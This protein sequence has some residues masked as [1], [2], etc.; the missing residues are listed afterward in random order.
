L[1]DGE[2]VI[3]GV[4]LAP[5]TCTRAVVT[6]AQISATAVLVTAVPAIEAGRA[7]A[8][9]SSYSD[10]LRVF[11]VDPG[12]LI[13]GPEGQE[14]PPSGGQ[15]DFLER[16]DATAS[17][18]LYDVGGQ[19]V[20]GAYAP[21]KYGWGVLVEEDG[22]LFDVEVPNAAAPTAAVLTGVFGAVFALVTWFDVRR[23]RAARRAEEDR[24][25]FLSIVGHE[26]RTPLTVI[27][28]YT[29]TLAARWD[30]LDESSRRM[31][32]E[33]MAP[34]A[35]RQARVIEH[36]LTAAALQAGT[37][38]RPAV[39]PMALP[40]VLE[41]VAAEY[42]IVAPL[43]DIRV[44]ASDVPPVLASDQSLGQI[45]SELLDNAVRFSPSGGAVTV[46]ALAR[47]RWV[48]VAVEDQGVGLP[49]DTGRLFQ[50]FGQ[51]EDVDRRVHAEGG[52][53]VGLFIVKTLAEMLGG[54]VRAE[55]GADGARFVVR[56][57]P[58]GRTAAVA[59]R[60]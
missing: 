5:V 42:R 47:G 22:A 12:G 20:V 31:L 39:E 35:Q 37:F 46:V 34:Q 33:S 9:A 25:A 27:K 50:P 7:G 49:A 16:R 48:E 55:R 17:A 45:V 38:A 21:A 10:V 6:V 56:L 8:P 28:G 36:L 15:A 51:G 18:E 41:R 54:E 2:P 43:H 3:S 19:R 29:E 52:I 30:A 24:D 26:L 60:L 59:A 4:I 23:R 11:A 32:V 58:A 14:A 1:G 13:V 44:S 40:P 57:R 53:G